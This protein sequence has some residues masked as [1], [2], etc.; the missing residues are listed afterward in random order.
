MPELARVDEVSVT[1]E[2]EL[3]RFEMPNLISEDLVITGTY[4]LFDNTQI[5]PNAKVTVK[6]GGVLDLG[7]YQLE[8]FGTLSLEGTAS[9]FA[10]LKNGTYKSEMATSGRLLSSWSVIENLSLE[11]WGGYGT[12]EFENSVFKDSFV[13]ALPLSSISNSLLIDSSLKASSTDELNIDTVTFKDST[14]RQLA[15]TKSEKT[16]PI[17]K[18]SNFIGKG[19]LIYLDPFFSG[20]GM[21]HN[22]RIINSYVS[23]SEGQTFDDLVYDSNDD[24]SVSRDLKARDFIEDPITNSS[25]GFTVGTYSVTTGELRGGAVSDAAPVAR[26]PGNSQLTSDGMELSLVSVIVA[27][28]GNNYTQY[29]FTYTETNNKTER[30]SQDSF[31]LVLSDGSIEP[32]YGFFNWVYPGETTTRTWTA[33]ILSSLTPVSLEY[34]KGFSWEQDAQS[35]VVWIYED[36]VFSIPIDTMPAQP[37]TL[38]PSSGDDGDLIPAES[39]SITHSLDVIVDLLG[40]VMLLKGLSE[41]ISGDLHTVEYNGISFDWSEVDSFVM[42]VVRDSEFTD[43]FSQ[44]I[45]D[46]YPSVAGISYQAAVT[47]IGTSSLDD[48]L[49][50]VAGAD[51]SY[52]S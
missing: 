35:E 10:T 48:V 31:S 52:V 12:L 41:T 32:Q 2:N 51:G 19:P 36:G 30:L 44:E 42:P 50:M 14:Y 25:D 5:G 47:F 17:I 43:E 3:T 33:S 26:M 11:D 46:A 38:D 6:P 34:A 8:N 49:M 15:W 29:T 21:S 18:D 16:G 4:S 27:D 37:E 7:Q 28:Q 45:A 23:V 9:S 22:L 24:F 39:P 20:L 40:N 13:E 1:E